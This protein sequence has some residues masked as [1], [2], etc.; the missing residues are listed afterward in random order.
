MKKSR[1]VAPITKI[2]P[3]IIAITVDL[4]IAHSLIWLFSS[5]RGLTVLADVYINIRAIIPKKTQL[6]VIPRINQYRSEIIPYLVLY[7]GVQLP[8]EPYGQVQI[9]RHIKSTCLLI[10]TGIFI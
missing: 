2:R 10:P 9:Q 3:K 7:H 1:C 6:I 4:R 8:G 5:R